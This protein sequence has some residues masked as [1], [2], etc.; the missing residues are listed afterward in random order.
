MDSGCC[1]GN[2]QLPLRLF[3]GKRW[4]ASSSGCFPGSSGL[5]LG[6]FPGN[7]GLCL[8]PAVSREAVDYLWAP[9]VFR[10]TVDYLWGSGCFGCFPGN[11]LLPHDWAPA[12]S[13]ET[14]DYLWALAVS[15]KA[16][17]YLAADYLWALA[18]SG[19]SRVTVDYLM[20]T[21]GLRLFPGKRWITSGL[22]PEKRGI[23]SGLQLFPGKRWITSGL[24]LFRLF[25]GKRW[26][27]SGLR[28][29]PGK[30]R[31]AFWASDVFLGNDGLPFWAPAIS[32]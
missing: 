24:W 26:I 10:E 25:P 13:R 29:L 14:V 18:V 7:D 1:P 22:W 19:V 21:S 17:D 5:P 30:R 11:G 16:V 27:T 32:R 9:A 3:P 23:T 2:G 12:V 6:C 31:I 15:R 4:I 8:A 20:I 28:L